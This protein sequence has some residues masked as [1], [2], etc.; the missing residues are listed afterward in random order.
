MKKTLRIV[1][2]VVLAVAIVFCS[3]WYLFVY[4]REFTRDMLLSCARFSENQGNHGVAAW[5][6]N[7]AYAQSGNNDDVA[8]ELANQYKSSGNY[9]KAEYTL[10]NA[11]ADG[12]DIDLYIALCQV[13]VEQD[14]L[15]DAVNM[16]NSVT[17]PDIK[18]KLDSMRPAA[19]QASPEPGL[20]NMYI[21]VTLQETEGTTYINASGEYPSTDSVYADPIPLGDGESSIYAVTIGQNGLVSPLS[22]FHYT[23]GGVIQK[24]EFSDS[25]IETEVRKLL[26][27]SADKELFTNDLWKITSF[28]VPAD[29][30]NYADLKHMLFLENLSIESGVSDQL[31]YISSLS[32][33]RQLSITKTDVSQDILKVIAGLPSLKELTVSNAN[34][35]GVA[36]LNSATGITKLD[37]SG[38][39]IRTIDA[40]SSMTGLQTLNLRS[41]AITDISALAANT[42][43]VSLD[44]SSNNITSLAPLSGLSSLTHLDASTNTVSDLGD[45]GKL[46]ALTN[47][48]LAKNKLTTVG[49]LSGCTSLVELNLSSNELTD[50]S[51]LSALVNLANFD[52]SYNQITSLPAFP[53]NSALVTITGSNNNLSSLEPL[54]GL[55]SLNTVNMDYNTEISSVSALANCPVLTRVNVYATKVTE[56]RVLTDQSIE[57]NYNPVQS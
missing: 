16:L 51:T 54:S 45:I 49:T 36:P 42:A 55:Q 34:L 37:L 31:Q 12:G 32:N 47:L 21:S 30:K 38:N 48:S 6:Y 5:F 3:V 13:Y 18:S 20:Y 22:I 19:P 9:T 8:I 26:D 25:A 39:T 24:M 33:L 40:I 56:V 46:T 41:N 10:S 17:N 52:F 15:L 28:T 29:A 44:I 27:V 1:I 50:I 14:K 23:I 53:V 7:F 35:S 57:V 43:L 2:P 11:I 4:D